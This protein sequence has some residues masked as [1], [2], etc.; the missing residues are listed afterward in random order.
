MYQILSN[1][2]TTHNQNLI[3]EFEIICFVCQKC[4]VHLTHRPDPLLASYFVFID[5]SSFLIGM[6]VVDQFKYSWSIS[7]HALFYVTSI[8]VPL[9]F[10]PA[11][12]EKKKPSRMSGTIMM[13]THSKVIKQNKNVVIPAARMT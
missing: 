4:T 6:C 10:A 5:G 9:G 1:T 11:N 13:W 7:S 3:L 2:S 12:K 8:T